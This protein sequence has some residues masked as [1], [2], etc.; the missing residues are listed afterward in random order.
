M[1]PWTAKRKA[2]DKKSL[3]VVGHLVGH[4]RVGVNSLI[5]GCRRGR[6]DGLFAFS[7]S[8]DIRSVGDIRDGG[9]CFDS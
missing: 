5:V 2:Y 9:D 1:R 8:V 3:Y 7:G 4:G 6:C